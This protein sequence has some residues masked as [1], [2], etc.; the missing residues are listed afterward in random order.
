MWESGRGNANVAEGAQGGRQG[1]RQAAGREGEGG[2]DRERLAL[3]AVFDGGEVAEV[4][5]R[6]LG[7]IVV[8][9]P[10]VRGTVSSVRSKWRIMHATFVWHTRTHTQTRTH[11]HTVICTHTALHNERLA[12][13]WLRPAAPPSLTQPLN[14]KPLSQPPP[15]PLSRTPEASSHLIEALADSVKGGEGA[16]PFPVFVLSDDASYARLD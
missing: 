11:A 5:H 3:G 16:A 6:Q 9:L 10:F 12:C 14:H 1:G 7:Q 15:P 8:L 4:G 2:T 13:T